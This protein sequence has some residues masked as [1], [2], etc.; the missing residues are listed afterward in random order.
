M[1]LAVMRDY[2]DD[3]LKKKQVERILV[4]IE[5]FH[6]I[7]T[8]I[9][10]QR[11]SGG[12]SQM[13][14]SSARRLTEAEYREEKLEIIKEQYKKLRER[15]PS[16]QEFEANF[17][18]L[19]YTEG[20]TT[21]KKLVQYILS[22]YHR[23]FGN[24]DIQDMTIEHLAPQSL[25]KDDIERESNVGQIGNLIYIPTELNQKLNTKDF[26]RKI[27]ILLKSGVKL[28]EPLLTAKQWTPADIEKRTKWLAELAFKT[29]WK[30]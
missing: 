29:I 3:I 1:V 25:G 18:E 5:K 4:A 19:Y 17:L 22:Q 6:F 7:F 14:A 9:T 15:V 11:S 12:I 10:S 30:I 23:H 16:Y 8:A 13:Y 27:K 2:R 21:Q 20:Y 24:P 28:D 26:K